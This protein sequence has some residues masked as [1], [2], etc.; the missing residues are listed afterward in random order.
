MSLLDELV[1][2]DSGVKPEARGDYAPSWRPASNRD[3]PDALEGTIAE[4]KSVPIKAENLKENGPT[5]DYVL[6]VEVSEAESWSVWGSARDLRDRFDVLNDDGLLV[7]GTTIAI[8]FFGSRQEKS[9]DG[10]PYT[11]HSYAVA[12]KAGAVE[13]SESIPF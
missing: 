3:H 12:A 1:S 11:V 10:R 2:T 13:Q 8:K 7:T 9:S 5:H 6:T 4:V